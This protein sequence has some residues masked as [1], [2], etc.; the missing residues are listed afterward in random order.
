MITTLLAHLG[1]FLVRPGGRRSSLIW[2]IFWAWLVLH[3]GKGPNGKAKLDVMVPY[4]LA[5]FAEDPA[6][7][8]SAAGGRTAAGAEPP[9]TAAI[10]A[11]GDLPPAAGGAR[12]PRRRRSGTRGRG[13]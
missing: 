7:A 5:G 3:I 6:A 9:R 13:R 8:M 12:T 11:A 1:S 2:R 10:A 4:L